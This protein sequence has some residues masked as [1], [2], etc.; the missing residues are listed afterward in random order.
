MY[1][2]ITS[3]APNASDLGYLLHKHPD[4]AQAFDVSG[5]VAHVFYPESNVQR[6]TVA[7]LLDVDPIALIR[8]RSPVAGD[9]ALGQY[10]NDRPY[11]ASSLLSVALGRVFRTALSGH[12]RSHPE[13]AASAL[14]LEI[15]VPVVPTSGGVAQVLGLFGPLGWTVTAEPIALDESIPQW[16]ESKYVDLRLTGTHVLAEALSHL[17]VLLPVLDG[18]KHYWVDDQEVDKL[19]RSSAS[20][21]PQHPQRAAIARGYLAGQRDL[22]ESALAQLVPETEGF[23]V[24][25]DQTPSDASPVR[26]HL[27]ALRVEAVVGALRDCAASRIVDYG[28]GEGALLRELIKHPEFTEIVGVDVSPRVLERAERLLQFDRMPDHQ[29]A[30]ITLRQSSVTYVDA[31]LAAYD[32]VVLMEV[33]EHVDLE[34]QPA[35][36]S[37]IFGAAAPTTVLVTTPNSE[38]NVLYDALA[39]GQFRHR[40]H[41]FE[42]TRAELATWSGDICDQFNYTVAIQGIGEPDP[43]VGAPTQMAIF[44]KERR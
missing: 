40:D 14:P 28:C 21:L 24:D 1:L 13:L 5:G 42:W 36:A 2:T 8:G 30:R 11:A 18:S 37:A 6:C 33:I 32:A 41:R 23:A 25:E 27:A 19:V 22:A 7:L 12:C 31:R 38:Y 9:F 3:T 44:T 43:D 20:W 16:G 35:L 39:A 15:H 17:Y 26:P 4:R 29:R 10:V 34:R